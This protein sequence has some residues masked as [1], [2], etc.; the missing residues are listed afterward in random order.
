MDASTVTY[1]VSWKNT[2]GGIESIDALESPVF[3]GRA[4]CIRKTII[5]VAGG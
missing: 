1:S 3:A 5:P 2:H 4:A